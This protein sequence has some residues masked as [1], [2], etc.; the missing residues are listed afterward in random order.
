MRVFKI[1][2][3]WSDRIDIWIQEKYKKQPKRRLRELQQDLFPNER[4]TKA[5]DEALRYGGD[6]TMIDR[7]EFA[8]E[9][10]LRESIRKVIKIVLEK[11]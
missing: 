3:D 9:L 7:Q 8:E 4:V 6:T 1:F 11:R 10:V 5:I 2:F